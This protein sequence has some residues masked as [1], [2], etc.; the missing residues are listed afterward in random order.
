MEKHKRYNDASEASNKNHEQ[1]PSGLVNANK[2]NKNMEYDV[3][4]KSNDPSTWAIPSGLASQWHTR[5]HEKP[6]VVILDWWQNLHEQDERI[7]EEFGPEKFSVLKNLLTQYDELRLAYTDSAQDQQALKRVYYSMIEQGLDTRKIGRI[8]GRGRADVV[9]SLLS[10][11]TLTVDDVIAR[12]E[13]EDLLR[14]GITL[15]ETA[16]LCDMHDH[17]VR[18]WAKTLQITPAA[19]PRTKGYNDEARE[20]AFAMYDSGIR[21]AEIVDVLNDRYPERK[22]KTMTVYKWMSRRRLGA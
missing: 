6:T 15:D 4:Y 18:Q 1:D 16:R 11:R 22:F 13:A 5:I 9:R 12:C 3:D 14:R 20:Q 10:N 7:Y 2:E 8:T 21:V 19:G 17:V